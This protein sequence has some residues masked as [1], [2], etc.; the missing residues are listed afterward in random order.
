MS[1]GVPITS[2]WIHLINISQ[3]SFAVDVDSVD[4]IVLDRKYDYKIIGINLFVV[5][6]QNNN[7]LIL[8]RYWQTINF[9]RRPGT[10]ESDPST[11]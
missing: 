8:W 1:I 11:R 10:F 5:T 3:A 7:R 9:G 6:F 2:C 4:I